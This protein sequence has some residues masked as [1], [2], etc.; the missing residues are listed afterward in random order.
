MSADR[1]QNLFRGED[2]GNSPP[3]Q[4][5][6]TDQEYPTLGEKVVEEEGSKETKSKPQAVK[7]SKNRV[8]NSGPKLH[9]ERS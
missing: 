2:G 8:E 9:E 4:P 6:G 1:K 7:T 3:F 5:P